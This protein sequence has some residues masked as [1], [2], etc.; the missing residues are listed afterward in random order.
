MP[1]DRDALDAALKH[2]Q[3]EHQRS[4]YEDATE[5]ERTEELI[6]DIER[7]LRYPDPQRTQDQLRRRMQEAVGEFEV[8]HPQLTAALGQIIDLLSGM[9]I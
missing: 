9:G 8:R 4:R 6:A 3:A 7:E 5:R 1:V 2:L